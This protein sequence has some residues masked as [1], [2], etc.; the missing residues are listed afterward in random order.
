MNDAPAPWIA[1]EGRPIIAAVGAVALAVA[2]GFWWLGTGP[3]V[4]ASF[5]ALAVVLWAVWFFRDPA[6]RIPEDEAAVLSGAD[7]VVCAVGPA[8]PPPELGLG[9]DDAGAMTR[10]SVFMNIF[11]VHVNRA[12]AAGAVE[13]I[14]YTP[15]RFFNA[16]LDKASEQN[17]RLAMLL[18]L[19]SGAPMVV[20]QI[21]GLV[22]RRI[23]CRVREG[24]SLRAGERFGLIRF[25]SRVDHYLPAGAEPCVSVGQKTVAGETVIARLAPAARGGAARAGEPVAA[26]ARGA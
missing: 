13:R 2:A 18:R 16:S 26:G 1:P 6:R 8:P 3:G 20:V 24:A 21:A 15:G 23:V 12:P 11:N 17:E 4:L 19:R 14:A 9:A 25:G 7:G 22:A 5:F 10:V